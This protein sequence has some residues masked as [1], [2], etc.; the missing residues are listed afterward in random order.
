MVENEFKCFNP[1]D[2]KTSDDKENVMEQEFGEDMEPPPPPA[3]E[4]STTELPSSSQDQPFPPPAP[5]NMDVVSKGFEDEFVQLE[6]AKESY[7]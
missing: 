7:A 4:P 6:T 2:E 1:T 5:S 3:P